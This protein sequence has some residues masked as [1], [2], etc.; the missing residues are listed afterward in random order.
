MIFMALDNGVK[1]LIPSRQRFL[2]F[3]SE[4]CIVLTAE[5]KNQK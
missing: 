4:L 2:T 3:E 1:M 5:A